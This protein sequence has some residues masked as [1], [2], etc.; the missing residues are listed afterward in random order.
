MPFD[1]NPLSLD[2]PALCLQCL[3]PPP[4]LFSSTQHPTSTSW[5]ITPPGDQ[6]HEGLALYFEEEFRKWKT[7]CSATTTTIMDEVTHPPAQSVVQ[8][9]NSTHLV[10][11]AEEA[12]NNLQRQ[13]TEHLAS[14]FY[15]WSQLP[16]SRQQELWILEMARNVGRKQKQVK[17]LKEAQHS[18]KQENTNLKSQIDHLNRQQ[19]PRE[20]KMVPP[21]T[22]K[23]D[24][25]LLELWTEAGVEGR[26]APGL[27]LEDRHSDLNTV[28]SGAIER[29]KSV[30]VSARAARGLNAQRSLDQPSAPLKTPTSATHPPSPVA[31]RT[32][33]QQF[34]QAGNPQ[35]HQ[36][37][38][39]ISNYPSSS[40]LRQL[41]LSPSGHP[42][43]TTNNSRT[44]MASTPTQSCSDLDDI[45]EDAE[46]DADD[47]VDADA[48]VD[49]EMQ[50][51]SQYLSSA[52][53]PTHHT[54]HQLPQHNSRQAHQ[55]HVT[56][57]Q[58][59]QMTAPRHNPYPPRSGSYASPGVLPSQQIHMAQQTFGH[60][61]QNLE[62][63]LG[64]A[65]GGVN[66][67]W[68]NHH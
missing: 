44:S 41:S 36:S 48:D 50:S 20:F 18:L 67:G 59:Q 33:K 62:H 63:H 15:V 12:A 64:Q 10:Q 58:S 4:T 68:N 11:K 31:S 57:S 52:N 29:W 43:A 17:N 60:Q 14:A 16:I 6:Q 55:M 25:R 1:F 47:D 19:Q 13:V 61:L 45:E 21:M 42:A 28:V 53:T 30:I 51:E 40:G 66:M 5:S 23:V 8:H 54:I 24:E 7:A 37:S 32:S 34:Q 38:P 49:V 27:N 2:F 46:G 3:E 65:H 9:E 22:M 56:R 26:P 39:N 35:Y